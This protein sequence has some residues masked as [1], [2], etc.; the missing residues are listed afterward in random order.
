MPTL[1]SHTDADAAAEALS[2]AVA[3]RLRLALAATPDAVVLAVSGGR[4][5]V[6]FFR[7]LAGQV[8][9]WRRV[10]VTLVDERLVPPGHADS[11]AGLVREHL[12][13]DLAAAARFRPLVPA[14]TTPQQI[15]AE[16]TAA[17]QTPAVTVL[18][19]G[20]DGHTAS[21]FPGAS[22]LAAG[23]AA[24]AAEPLLLLTPPV[25]PHD[26][27]GMTAAEIARSGQV[28][29]S[30]SGPVKRA[31]LAQALS[32]SVQ[33]TDPKNHSFPVASVLQQAPSAVVF[34]TE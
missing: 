6:P 10:T 7:A 4:S 27:I 13:A 12:L 8:L 22:A 15:L 11:N 24:G 1:L 5:P 33:D 14:L 26:R 20:E 3:A 25:A 19:M 2:E 32:Q 30:V 34:C 29:L 16:A 23:L 21:L 18:G 9:D 28:F 17:W 31:V